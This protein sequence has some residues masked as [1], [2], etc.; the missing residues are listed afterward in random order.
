MSKV[1]KIINI[2]IESP[3]IDCKNRHPA[4]QDECEE[5]KLYKLKIYKIKKELKEISKEY[6]NWK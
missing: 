5:L 3:C 4:C 2:D 6:E 1:F